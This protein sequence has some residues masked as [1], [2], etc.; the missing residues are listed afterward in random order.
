[1]LND[2]AQ[3]PERWRTAGSGA[4]A[5]KTRANIYDGDE[6]LTM[7]P[8]LMDEEE[9]AEWIRV[10]MYRK[11]HA[12]EYAEQQR[13]KAAQ[14]ARKAEEKARKAETA[15]LEKVAEEERKQKKLERESRRLDYAREEYNKR[16]AALLAIAGEGVGENAQPNA[17][18]ALLS[19]DDIPWPIA[20]AHR[21]KP[22]KRR[23]T[24]VGDREE[25]VGVPRT[26]ISVEELTADA[27][28]SFLLPVA[29]AAADMDNAAKKKE[30][31]DKLREHSFEEWENVREAIGQVSRVLNSLMGNDD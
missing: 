19:F 22:E 9:Y 28:S 10:G 18:A 13:K 2:F 4:T 16:W 12:E 27:I 17:A 29:A 7:D 6:F 21:D 23:H 24:K 5:G 11:T 30:R 3:V 14:A 31:K 25:D 26:S 1:R 15:R 8:R 20:I